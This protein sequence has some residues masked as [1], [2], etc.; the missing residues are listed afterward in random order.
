MMNGMRGR[1]DSPAHLLHSASF[2]LRVTCL[3]LMCCLEP[4]AKARQ[5]DSKRLCAGG[6]APAAKKYSAISQHHSAQPSRSSDL[7][8]GT[9]ASRSFPSCSTSAF[10]LRLPSHLAC[11][12]SST[13]I[14]LGNLQMHHAREIHLIRLHNLPSVSSMTL[15]ARWQ[16]LAE[17][18]EMRR[19]WLFWIPGSVC[20]ESK[21]PSR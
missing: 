7:L 5:T 15:I 11:S 6:S 14:V 21:L 17:C 9:E 8:F 19:P 16:T 10:S 20:A 3:K 18:P 1:D 4:R 2:T 13:D 12:V